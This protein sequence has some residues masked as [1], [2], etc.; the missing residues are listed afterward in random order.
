M[1]ASKANSRRFLFSKGSHFKKKAFAAFCILWGAFFAVYA[2]IWGV[3]PHNDVL[4]NFQIKPMHLENPSYSALRLDERIGVDDMRHISVAVV[5]LARN[6]ERTLPSVLEQ[7]EVLCT[8]FAACRAY[9]AEG[10]SGDASRAIL[11]NWAGK[12]AYNRTVVDVSGLQGLTETTGPQ[13]GRGMPREGRIAMAR[14]III[15]ELNAAAAATEDSTN[16]VDYVIV[17]DSDV[18][19]WD[20]RGIAHTFSLLQGRGSGGVVSNTW[21]VMCSYGIYREG[22][23]RDTYAFRTADINTNHHWA[24]S[25]HADY[26]VSSA[27]HDRNRL[28]HQHDTARVRALVWQQHQEQEQ[29]PHEVESCFGGLAIYR[30]AQFTGCRYGHRH[31]SPPHM[32]DCEH[33]IFNKCL[34]DRYGARIYTNPRMRLWYGHSGFFDVKLVASTLFNVQKWWQGSSSSAR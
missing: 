15:S 21:D 20:L 25:D 19:G 22:V 6:S 23:Y 9:F 7:V 3:T 12:S 34:R 24:G 30:H 8:L 18:L 13:A 5:G 33:V 17:I 14:N 27:D 4:L 2:A 31:T 28:R 16:K 10:D 11:Q 29:R 26:N 1:K 32:L